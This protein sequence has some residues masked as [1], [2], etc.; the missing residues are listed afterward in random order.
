MSYTWDT[1]DP[2]YDELPP[3]TISCSGHGLQVTTNLH[4]AL[5]QIRDDMDDTILWIDAICIDQDNDEEKGSQVQLMGRIYSEAEEVIIWLGVEEPN[6]EE[7]LE[8]IL[9][10]SDFVKA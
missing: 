8:L 10:F 4:A 2:A 3:S 5:K 7:A 9:R 1:G 6:D